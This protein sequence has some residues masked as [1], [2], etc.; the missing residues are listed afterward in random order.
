MGFRYQLATQDGDVFEQAEYAYEPLVGDVVR[1]AGRRPMRVTGYVRAE[2]FAEF[3][4]Q[5]VYGLLEL[6]PV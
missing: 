5:A 2:R 1:L 4:D 6:E 3:V